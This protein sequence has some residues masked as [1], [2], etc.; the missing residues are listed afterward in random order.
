MVPCIY[1]NK[2]ENHASSAENN[3]GI[4]SPSD[5]P[6]VSESSESTSRRTISPTLP[7]P[8][9][10]YGADSETSPSADQNDSDVYDIPE[11]KSRRMLELR[12]LQNYLTCVSQPFGIAQTAEVHAAWTIEVPKLAFRYEN[13]LFAIFTISAT[14]MLR[15]EPG[16]SD[17]ISARQNYLGLALREQ[18]RVVAQLSKENADAICF[19][20]MLILMNAFAT[21]QERSI[22]P[23]SPPVAWLQL[24][25]GASSVF[26]VALSLIQDHDAARIIP[27]VNA[28]P[29]FDLNNEAVYSDQNRKP[30]ASLLRMD[31]ASEEEIWDNENREAYEQTLGYLGS[32]QRAISEK[33]TVV[34]LCRRLLAFAILIPKRFIELLDQQR[35]RA[36]V[37]LAHYFGLMAK[38]DGVWWIGNSAQREIRGIQNILS[39][40][41]QDQLGWPLGMA[42]LSPR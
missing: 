15:D 31:I 36:L 12:L 24:G 32:I 18:S 23:Y 8:G 10:D 13:L 7:T 19:A 3:N 28:G 1:G 21:L 29:E 17:L 33:E 27:V 39:P 6:G 2:T 30:F 16:N 26:K 14:H 4:W 20:S 9:L 42:G 22:E 25:R 34:S 5:R 38:V 41:W 35:P 37:I 11:S 40:T